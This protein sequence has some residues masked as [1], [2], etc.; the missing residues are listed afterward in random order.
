MASLNHAIVNAE[1]FV[2]VTTHIMDEKFDTGPIIA[3]TKIPIEF[4]KE[5]YVELIDDDGAVRE[6][7]GPLRGN[8]CEELY[9]RCLPVSL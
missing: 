7:I 9:M 3:Q 2:G 8:T 4:E 1:E 5:R 6:K